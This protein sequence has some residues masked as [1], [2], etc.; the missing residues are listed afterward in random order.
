[1][2]RCK[3]CQSLITLSLSGE[4]TTTAE[5]ALKEHLASC[6]VCRTA[7]VEETALGAFLGTRAA[8]A[9]ALGVAPPWRPAGL[10]LVPATASQP[11]SALQRA[12]LLLTAAAGL[13]LLVVWVGAPELT[14]LPPRPD[15]DPTS[16]TR[17]EKQLAV[18]EGYDVSLFAAGIADAR[19]LRVT[20]AGDVLVSSPRNGRI[21][22]LEADR[23]GNGAADGE[24]VLLKGLKRPNGLDLNGAYLYVAE[25]D[26]VGRIAF[27]ARSGTVRGGYERIIEGLPSGGSHWKKTIRFG[28][29]GLLYV[30]VGASCNACV[31]ED[32]RRAA[33][34]RYTPEGEFVDRYATGLR[35]SVGFDWSPTTGVLYATDN[36]RDLLGD[37]FPPCELNA[38]VE[39]GFYG[40][41]FAHGSNVPDPDLADR[42]HPAIATAI[43]PVHEFRP[44]NAPLGM[45]FLR[46]DGHPLGYR[47]AAIVALHGS[48]ARAEKDGYK[49]V[50]LHFGPDG[51]IEERDLLTGFLVGNR[52]L[53]RPAGV[54]EGPDGSI[55]VSD[56]FASAVYRIRYGA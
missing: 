18:P 6:E 2:N 33:L 52:A 5:P 56:D 1:M 3:A 29:D 26:A 50:S 21:M 42:D 15:A 16:G 38:V 47:D 32:G 9:R 53:G 34:L 35:N 13:A 25:E 41:P 19:T 12:A 11:L 45:V 27:D 36:G 48:W 4:T 8:R 46:H 22:L 55:Y 40:W 54:A 31:E 51:S 44:H 7:F 30:A 43:T 20:S 28:P 10:G 17:I 49:V 37:D 39:D 23:D 24:R 14:R